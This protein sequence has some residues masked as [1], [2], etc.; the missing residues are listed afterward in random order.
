MTERYQV[1]DL[2]GVRI[3]PAQKT[4]EAAQKYAARIR[5]E[6]M[7]GNRVGLTIMRVVWYGS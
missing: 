4:R 3:E 2:A 7:V 5:S 1:T 6:K